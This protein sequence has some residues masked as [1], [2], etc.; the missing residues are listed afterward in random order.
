MAVQASGRPDSAV[1]LP[2][3]GGHGYAAKTWAAA[4]GWFAES[5][6]YEAWGAEQRMGV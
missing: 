5:Q 1:L 6:R 2:E 3:A 4:L